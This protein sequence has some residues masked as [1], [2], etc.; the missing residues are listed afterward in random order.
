M[1]KS[2]NRLGLI[3]MVAAM[4]MMGTVGI[5]VVESGQNAY[6]VV[7]FRCIFGSLF[8]ALY[9][10]FRGFFKN[11]G[12]TRN[13]SFLV[14]LSGI[15]LVFNWV[16]LFASFETST[17]SI[18]TTIYHTQPFFFLLIGSIVF[19]EVITLDKVL[20]IFLAF[21]GVILVSDI[22]AGSLSMSSEQLRG[23]V[24]A[25]TAALLWAITAVIVKRVTSIKPHLIALI[26]VFV[27]I[28]ALYPFT[29]LEV[30]GNT[31]AMQW[32]YLVALGGI[33]T[34]LTY[35]LMY[36]AFQKLQTAIISVLTFIYPAVAILADF[37]VYDVVLS[38]LQMIGVILILFSSFATSRNVSV[39]SKRKHKRAT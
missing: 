12:L 24:Y 28:F 9:C 27:G 37:L 3:E 33:H 29:T 4:I 34:C 30:I 36:S 16:L 19:K 11:T 20:W 21:A 39:L 18:A 8:L 1:S 38:M 25:L 26:Q 35:I 14:V 10:Y 7:F 23:V 17:I 22:D 5:F 6:N 31:N 2:K 15:F 32:G 13:V